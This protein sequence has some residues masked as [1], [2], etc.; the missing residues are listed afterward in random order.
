[1]S[2]VLINISEEEDKQEKTGHNETGDKG[3]NKDDLYD[4]CYLYLIRDRYWLVEGGTHEDK[5]NSG[6]ETGIINGL[7]LHYRIQ[8]ETSDNHLLELY[9]K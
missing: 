6:A 2:F 9:N 8:F 7:P 3:T 5:T 4:P 1:M